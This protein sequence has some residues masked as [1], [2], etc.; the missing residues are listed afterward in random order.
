ESGFCRTRSLSQSREH[1]PGGA[2][3]I[4]VPRHILP[5][6]RSP[7]SPRR[8]FY[9]TLHQI[10]GRR[11]SPAGLFHTLSRFRRSDVIRWIA[12]IAGWISAEN[13][14][15]FDGQLAMADHLLTKDLRAQLGKCTQHHGRTACLFHRRQLLFLLQLATIA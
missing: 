4:L 12:G 1:P 9:Y 2:M 13:G 5:P 11:A 14:M 10:C 15:D 6:M 7:T 8:G 3:P